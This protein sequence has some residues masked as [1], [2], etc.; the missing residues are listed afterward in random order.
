L[1]C[2]ILIIKSIFILIF[3]NS[4][5]FYNC[6]FQIIMTIEYKQL[7]YHYT[8]KIN[9]S[10]WIVVYLQYYYTYSWILDHICIIR[11]VYI[12]IYIYIIIICRNI[13]FIS[14][15]RNWKKVKEGIVFTVRIILSVQSGKEWLKERVAIGQT[16]HTE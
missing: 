11:C 16:E 12:Y 2:F 4:Y 13:D 5:E 1:D 9:S 8:K 10:L 3:D 14:W 15:I 7:C 6:W